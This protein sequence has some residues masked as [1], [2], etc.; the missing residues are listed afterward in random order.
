MEAVCKTCKGLGRV[1]D[2]STHKYVPCPECAKRRKEE[3]RTGAITYEKFGLEAPDL[4]NEFSYT[5][6][7]KY[8]NTLYKKKS[9]DTQKEYITNLLANLDKH[10]RPTESVCFGLGKHGR[11]DVLAYAIAGMAYSAG[12]SVAPVITCRKL[13]ELSVF[14]KSEV[15]TY[16]NSEILII[17]IPVNPTRAS[18]RHSVGIMQERAMADKPTIFI[19]TYE[20][21]KCKELLGG[22]GERAGKWLAKAVF[23]EPKESVNEAEEVAKDNIGLVEED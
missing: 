8:A 21:N 6:A 23:V 4:S 7:V 14:E 2:Y 12:A 22:K 17:V 9:V 18:L 3:I 15:S 11:P 13:Y 20:Q 5:K 1:M 10:I 16:I 19:T